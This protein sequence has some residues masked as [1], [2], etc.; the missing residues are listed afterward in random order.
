MVDCRQTPLHPGEG[1]GSLTSGD[2]SSSGFR[3]SSA[4]VTSMSPRMVRRWRAMAACCS[5][6]QWFSR[7]KMTGYG[8]SCG[9][10][11]QQL[12]VTHS[13][14]LP[15]TPARTLAIP[16]PQPP[17]G[18]VGKDAA[19]ENPLWGGLSRWDWDT[20]WDRE[21]QSGRCQIWGLREGVGCLGG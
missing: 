2:G 11:A 19:L 5:S 9:E 14:S 7:D 15:F 17:S 8:E 13:F 3:E 1:S 20:R 12:R 18:Q 6:P 4:C 21:T 16:R 10:E